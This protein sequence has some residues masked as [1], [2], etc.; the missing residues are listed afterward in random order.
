MTEPGGPRSRSSRAAHRGQRQPAAVLL[1]ILLALCAVAVAV[2]VITRALGGTGEPT[3]ASPTPTPTP[4]PSSTH[5]A[6]SRTPSPT[7][8]STSSASHSASPT[9]TASHSASPTS[10]TKLPVTV[11]NQTSVPGAAAALAA[12]L[13]AKGWPVR[14]VDNWRGFVP[15]TTVY[16]WPGDEASARLLA[17]QFPEVGRIRPASAPMPSSGLVV[18]IAG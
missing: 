10:A 8:S 7:P 9:P 12:K 16:Y 11:F 15:S 2:V 13:T 17:A 14:A 6:A 3:A 1:P 18:I 5:S 4:T